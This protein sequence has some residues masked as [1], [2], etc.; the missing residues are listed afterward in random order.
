MA[1]HPEGHR[2]KNTILQSLFL[3]MEAQGVQTHPSIEPYHF[4]RHDSG[5]RTVSVLEVRKNTSLLCSLSHLLPPGLL[6]VSLTR[7][8][9]PDLELFQAIRPTAAWFA[10]PHPFF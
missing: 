1:P 6:E 9:R 10:S 2:S 3:S 5:I 7:T 8:T 4:L